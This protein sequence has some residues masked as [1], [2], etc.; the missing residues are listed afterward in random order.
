V[1]GTTIS[2]LSTQYVL[3]PIRA[4]S[5]GVLYNP[6]ALEVQMAFIAGWSKPTE[7]SWQ[8]AEWAWTTSENGYYSAQ[9]LIGPGDGGYDLAVG[10]YNV[11]VQVTGSPE[12]PVLQSVGTLTIT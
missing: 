11:W 8:P 10:T 12:V 6:T 5:E 9:C 4:F 3:V 2:S 1:P 7:E